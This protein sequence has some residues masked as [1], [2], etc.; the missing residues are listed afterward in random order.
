VTEKGSRARRSDTTTVAII[1]NMKREEYNGKYGP[2]DQ[3]KDGGNDEQHSGGH[4]P[5]RAASN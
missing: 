3:N 1:R 4:S 2:I 5:D